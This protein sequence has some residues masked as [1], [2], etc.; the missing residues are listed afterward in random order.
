[1]SDLSRWVLALI[2]TPLLAGCCTAMTDQTDGYAQG[3]RRARIEAIVDGQAPV[4][5]AYRDCRQADPANTAAGPY[6]LA[7]YSFGGNP[8]LRHA[9][10]VP[11]PADMRLIVGQPVRI[12]ITHCESALPATQP[13]H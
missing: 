12:N 11:A 6:V 4:R 3:W 1:M 9:M 13:A 5:S 7:S 8:N 2:S 10:V